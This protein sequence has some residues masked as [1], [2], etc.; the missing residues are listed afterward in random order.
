MKGDDVCW[1][2]GGKEERSMRIELMVRERETAMSSDS[3]TTIVPLKPVGEIEDIIIIKVLC[4][5]SIHVKL[6]A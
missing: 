3:A 6:S 2:A 5:Y 1:Q 4:N